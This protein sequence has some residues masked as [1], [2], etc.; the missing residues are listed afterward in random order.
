MY[1]RF[2]YAKHSKDEELPA[3]ARCI[4]LLASQDC[5]LQLVHIAVM[6]L[7]EMHCS[8][9]TKGVHFMHS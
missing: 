4:H 8:W 2:V 7:N 9:H 6:R 3:I 1:C 5:V